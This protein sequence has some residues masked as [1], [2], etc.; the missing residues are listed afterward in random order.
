V[1]VLSERHGLGL[2]P[3][4]PAAR[5]VTGPGWGWVAAPAR[6][7]ADYAATPVVPTELCASLLLS[8]A[9]AV[10]KRRTTTVWRHSVL[11]KTRIFA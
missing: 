11:E 5:N 4:P 6:I 7:A 3:V 2:C 9:A 10:R 8:G 1:T